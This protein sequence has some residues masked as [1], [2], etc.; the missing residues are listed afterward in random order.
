MKWMI[1]AVMAFTYPNGAKDYY[2]WPEPNFDSIQECKYFG[3]QAIPVLRRSLMET[4]GPEKQ[5]E[6]I[7]CVSMDVVN[8]LLAKDELN[9]I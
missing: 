5:I 3:R 2:I 9:V 4:Y 6:M 7:S 1:V 8:D